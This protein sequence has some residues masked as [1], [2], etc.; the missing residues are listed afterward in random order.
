[1]R[2]N[3]GVSLSVG[4]K[5]LGVG[6]KQFSFVKIE[7]QDKHRIQLMEIIQCVYVLTTADSASALRRA[8]E[9][10]CPKCLSKLALM[11]CPTLASSCRVL[12][13]AME[14]KYQH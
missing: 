5:K 2:G 7:C 4:L 8:L 14:I 10:E 6:R 3:G 9:T 13:S 11:T 12:A 1:M